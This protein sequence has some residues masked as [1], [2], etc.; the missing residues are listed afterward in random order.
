MDLKIFMGKG[1]IGKRFFKR[2]AEAVALELL[3]RVLVRR[4]GKRLL[5]GRIVE[6]EAYLGGEDSGSWAHLGK[7]KDN[8]AMWGAP[9]TI[10][11]KNVH[12][13]HMLN[14]VTGKERVPQAVLI[15]ALEPLNFEAR[16]SGPG[17]L[18]IAMKIDKSFNGKDV[19]SDKDI[20]IE[21]SGE[22]VEV[23]KS[24]RIGLKKDLEEHMRFYLKDNEYV[25]GK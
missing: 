12:K 5:C 19:T 18:T 11:V 17:L 6:T 7:R 8:S 23:A 22:R 1:K 16:C 21:G 24:F 25:S 9:G 2:N 14:F 15:R 4:V 13:Y 20:W 3:G 10:L